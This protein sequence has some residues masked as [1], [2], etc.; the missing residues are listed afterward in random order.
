MVGEILG[1]QNLIVERMTVKANEDIEKGEIV[2]NDGNGILAAA[3]AT[4]GPFFV[5]LEALDYSAV[6]V[7]TIRVGV[8]GHFKVQKVSA[9]GANQH[10]RYVELSTTAGEVTIYDY[11]SPG[12][13]FDIV[14]IQTETS[15]DADTDVNIRIGM[16]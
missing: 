8:F 5:A 4:L 1:E 6:S 7:Y 3:A 10:G 2:Q 12:D 15:L 13:W 16:K 9:A 11:S 14:G